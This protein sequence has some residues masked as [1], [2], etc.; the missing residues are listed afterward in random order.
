MIVD[1]MGVRLERE[2]RWRST[3]EIY[4]LRQASTESYSLD[5]TLRR[6]WGSLTTAGGH[7]YNKKLTQLCN[8]YFY[9]V[10]VSRSRVF[11]GNVQIPTFFLEQHPPLVF[12]KLVLSVCFQ[13]DFFCIG[14]AAFSRTFRK[15]PNFTSRSFRMDRMYI[16]PTIYRVT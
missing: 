16:H 7:L 9:G 6:K 12:L 1:F 2:R 5:A 11:M 14:S 10:T 3:N 13:A 8:I 4:Y 15:T